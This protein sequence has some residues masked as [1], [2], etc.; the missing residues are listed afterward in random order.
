MNEFKYSSNHSCFNISH[1]RHG[2]TV[3]KVIL[4]LQ[5][6]SGVDPGNLILPILKDDCV[7][8]D[9]V[10][11]DTRVTPPLIAI[12]IESVLDAVES[13]MKDAKMVSILAIIAVFSTV[14]AETVD[15]GSGTVKLSLKNLLSDIER[16]PF[17]D[18]A[19]EMT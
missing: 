7:M 12:G 8:I 17:L 18:I 16:L 14:E 13:S 5:A 10:G 19:R 1:R 11:C 3:P 4:N 9:E 6:S 15:A 2:V